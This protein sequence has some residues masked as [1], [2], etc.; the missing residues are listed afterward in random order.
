MATAQG[1]LDMQVLEHVY[2]NCSDDQSASIAGLRERFGESNTAAITSSLKSRGLLRADKRMSAGYFVTPEGRAEV[3][4]MRNRRTDR[5]LRR[6]L[7]RNQLLRWIDDQGASQASTRVARED[8]DASPD[9][10]PFTDLETEA[11]ADHLKQLGLVESIS[12]DQ[13]DHILLWTTDRGRQ[14]LDAGGDVSAFARVDVEPSAS[15]VFNI[16]GSGNRV[17]AAIGSNNQVTA[18]LT[19]FDSDAAA[20]FAEAVQQAVAALGLD[21]DRVA[22][23]VVDVQQTKDLTRAQRAT[24]LLQTMVVGTTTGTLGQVLGVLGASALGIGN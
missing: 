17:A 20:Q 22:Q 8:F 1:D 15:Q 24:A 13:A 11:A 2:E 12:V 4:E 18:S 10:L 3:E 14:C 6:R 23:L 19:T 21:A 16:T 7:C 5:G 9:L